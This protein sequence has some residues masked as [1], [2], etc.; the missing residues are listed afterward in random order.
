[1]SEAV[2]IAKQVCEGLTE[3]HRLGVVHRDLKPHN[4]M[5]NKDG[6]AKIMDFGIAT[7]VDAPGVRRIKNISFP[8]GDIAGLYSLPSLIETIPGANTSGI[9]PGGC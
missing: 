4:I 8:S 1:M 5:I 6:L 3:A 2:E 7:S 9:L